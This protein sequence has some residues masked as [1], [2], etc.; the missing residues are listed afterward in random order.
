MDTEQH[1]GSCE[2]TVLSMVGTVIWG[3]ASVELSAP[4][5][6]L[7]QEVAATLSQPPVALTL[8][9]GTQLLQPSRSLAA[10]GL[11]AGAK[12]ELTAVVSAERVEIADALFARAAGSIQV[13]ETAWVTTPFS[14]EHVAYYEATV[15]RL[16][17]EWVTTWERRRVKAGRASGANG[18]DDPGSDS[19][20]EEV[21][22]SA[23]EPR[24]EVQER[25]SLVAPRLLLDDG[26]GQ[27]AALMPGDLER[28][29]A[30]NAE[31]TFSRTE[32]APA[33]GL[34]TR[35][36]ATERERGVRREER[37]I[38]LGEAAEVVAEALATEDGL[39]LREPQRPSEQLHR[40]DS[41]SQC[42]D[43]AASSLRGK[44]FLG[45]VLRGRR[46]LEEA[47][48]G[49]AA[50]LRAAK[51]LAAAVALLLAGRATRR[52]PRGRWPRGRWPWGR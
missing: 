17:D 46:S 8:L 25:R 33:P 29:A 48:L 15:V 38:R 36:W 5:A 35:L 14:G 43:G 1:V 45:A 40:V 41:L 11:Q 7:Q 39:V 44:A 9:L 31:A 21:E 26:S 52:W 13:P 6:D 2:V 10:L 34:G 12:A 20:Y 30:E 4:V 42:A 24:E 49:R 51:L 22:R 50:W 18:E 37:C 16:Y 32:N 47:L 28:W 19:E 3:P 27:P 23:W